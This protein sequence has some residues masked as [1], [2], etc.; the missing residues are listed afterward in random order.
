M[1]IVYIAF[2]AFIIGGIIFIATGVSAQRSS[3]KW[4]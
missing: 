4:Y 3:R 2:G 1:L